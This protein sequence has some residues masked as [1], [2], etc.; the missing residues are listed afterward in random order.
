MLSS[1]LSDCEN[2]HP[3][4]A[5]AVLCPTETLHAAFIH[6]IVGRWTR[7]S[8]FDIHVIKGKLL[9]SRNVLKSEEGQI[10]NPSVE[11]IVAHSEQAAVRVAAVVDETCWAAHL[12]SVCH[13]A[14]ALVERTRLIIV[15]GMLV[16]GKQV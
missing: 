16:Q 6:N 11:A 9:T 10:I 2:S 1:N 4:L 14:V 7:F 3:Q 8:F 15:F 5:S 13:V 12:L